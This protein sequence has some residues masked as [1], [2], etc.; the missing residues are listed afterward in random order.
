MGEPVAELSLYG[1][2]PVVEA[3]SHLMLPLFWPGIVGQIEK[4]RIGSFAFKLVFFSGHGKIPKG[5]LQV[6]ADG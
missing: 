2:R 3:G 6:S 4:N 1:P 5:L